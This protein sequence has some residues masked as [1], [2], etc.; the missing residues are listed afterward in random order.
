MYVYIRVYIC[1][2]LMLNYLVF[3]LIICISP[4]FGFTATW[5]YEFRVLV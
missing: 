5:Y 3:I 2:R 4:R 1:M